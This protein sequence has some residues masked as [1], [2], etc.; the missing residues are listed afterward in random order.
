MTRRPAEP[1]LFPYT[2]LFRSDEPAQD[3]GMG[4]S[5]THRQD[6]RLR[7]REE[8]ALRDLV[9]A[10]LVRSEERRVGKECRS[11]WSPDH[12]KKKKKKEEDV[13]GWG[14]DARSGAQLMD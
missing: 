9:D 3:A 5:N 1:P 12:E 4:A 14:D 13:H 10:R 11:R 6:A 7:H 2:T 8:V